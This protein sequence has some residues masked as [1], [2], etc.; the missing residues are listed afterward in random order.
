MRDAKL[1]EL[2]NIEL[3]MESIS[4]KTEAWRRLKKRRDELYALLHPDEKK[5]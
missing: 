5:I 3:D 2:Y 1:S 4:P